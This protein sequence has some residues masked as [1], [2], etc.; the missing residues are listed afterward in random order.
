MSDDD[1]ITYC[2][3]YCGLCAE[4]TVLPS[5][6]Q[7][8]LDLVKDEGYDLFYEYIPGM[9]EQ[10]PSFINVLK[11]LSA[12]DCRCRNGSGGPPDCEIRA[13]AKQRNVFVCM[14][15]PEFPCRKWDTIA[16]SYPLLAVDA[17]RYR[18]LGKERW[19]EEQ[20]AKARKGLNYRMLR[21]VDVQAP[22]Q[23]ERGDRA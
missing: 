23:P 10:Y 12:M 19:L 17:L 6:A 2:G 21:V 20:R 9:K 13:C 15:C 8:L 4:R 16:R 3:L 11:D 5:R 7:E 14:E 1:F 18:E 22:D